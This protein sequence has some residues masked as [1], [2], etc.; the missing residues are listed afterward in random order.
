MLNSILNTNWVRKSNSNDSDISNNSLSSSA[1]ATLVSASCP[2]TSSA[3]SPTSAITVQT[4]SSSGSTTGPSVMSFFWN[5]MNNIYSSTSSNNAT[6]VENSKYINSTTNII[7]T[8][9]PS[10]PSLNDSTRGFSDYSHFA[11]DLTNIQRLKAAAASQGSLSGI[12]EVGILSDEL[13]KS[14]AS[15]DL[16]RLRIAVQRVRGD[17]IEKGN[18]DGATALHVAAGQ[19]H[20]FIVGELLDR[21]V[22]VFAVDKH[23]R[24]PLHLAAAEGHLP[25]ISLLLGNR[26]CQIGGAVSS[27]LASTTTGMNPVGMAGAVLHHQQQ[28]AAVHCTATNRAYAQL[29]ARDKMGR[30]A[31][32]H[33][34]MNGQ[35]AAVDLLLRSGSNPRSRCPIPGSQVRDG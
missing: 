10:S 3:V 35:T 2:P 22:K 20:T 12:I 13:L 34:I 30:D 14:A 31:L 23:G 8:I 26:G 33:A 25:V 24:I 17:Y 29:E 16:S 27:A 6:D 21:Q 11:S 9:S 4:S 19:G 15:G 28:M 5:G 18:R 1:G 32:F 7:H